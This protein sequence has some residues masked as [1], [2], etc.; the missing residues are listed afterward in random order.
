MILHLDLRSANILLKYDEKE[1]TLSPQISNFLWSK[2]L[3]SQS[4]VHPKIPIPTEEKV[5]RRWHDPIRLHNERSFEH[6]LP[7]SDIYSL[8]LLFWEIAWCK[9]GNFPFKD[10]PIKKLFD[11]LRSNNHEKLPEMPEEY[12]RWKHLISKMWQF[13]SENRYRISDVES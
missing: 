13:K 10:V 4:S 2:Y 1:K 9:A 3:Y 12:R 7:S 8:G 6:I 11:H 5:W